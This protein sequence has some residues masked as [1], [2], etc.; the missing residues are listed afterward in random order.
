M[1]MNNIKFL[2]KHFIF[3]GVHLDLN[4]L[5]ESK[6]QRN[7]GMWHNRERKI[8]SIRMKHCVTSGLF[9]LKWSL[10]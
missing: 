3:W 5:D 7:V 8:K 10:L 2:A 1:E 9:I 4:K 6:G